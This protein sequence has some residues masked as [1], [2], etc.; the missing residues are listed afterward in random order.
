MDIDARIKRRQRRN[1]GPRLIVDYEALS[2]VAHMEDPAGRGPVLERLLDHLDPAFDG[3]LPPN[4]YVTGP[5]GSGKSALVTTL[6]THLD[7]LSNETASIIHTSTRAATPTS[8]GFVYV[9]V[10]ETGSE[11]GFYHAVLDALV[12]EAVPHHGISTEEV[13]E[14]LHERLGQSR[15]GVVV[16]VD[17]VCEPDGTDAETLVER[18]AALPSNVSW[19]A[20]GRKPPAA[21]PLTEY[22]GTTIR[23]DPYRRET[24]VDVVMTRASLGLTQQALDHDQAR[25]I[26]EWASG[27]AH[28]ALAA[29]FVAADRASQADRTRLTDEDVQAA[30]EEFPDSS[31]SL[32]RVL[33]LPANKKLVLREL[34][35]LDDGARASVTETTEAISES[36]AIDLSA[37][38]VK[39]YLY[40]MSE[41]GIV[42]RVQLP[43][44]DGKGRPPS[45]V[46]LRFS[47]T[48]FRR[49]YELNAAATGGR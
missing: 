9:D 48:A 19:L 2:P 20:I 21:V 43:A 45:R 34:V 11:F 47:P 6:F 25:R 22:T 30:I 8:P 31:V 39:R 42:E 27:N 16:A 12:D 40:E 46:A 3:T 23:I 33:A 5:F 15:A 49:L 44:T 36:P 37:G 1:A 41:A 35:A 38:T 26:A 13:R 28:D 7:R 10:R 24:L 29:L 4:A 18:F 32:A 17:H 14:Q